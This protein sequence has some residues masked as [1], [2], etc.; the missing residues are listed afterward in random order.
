MAND[1]KGK[2]Q[3]AE[4]NRGD[5]WYAVLRIARITLAGLVLYRYMTN[6]PLMLALG[7]CVTTATGWM[8]SSHPPSPGSLR[9]PMEEEHKKENQRASRWG[10][11]DA[12]WGV[13][14]LGVERR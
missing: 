12:R 5:S 8:S 6:V 7:L 4:D 1:L 2:S 13:R 11:L 14:W 10:R 3:P 9:G